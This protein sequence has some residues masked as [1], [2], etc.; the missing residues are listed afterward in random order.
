MTVTINQLV[1]EFSVSNFEKS[2]AFYVKILGFSIAYQREEEGFAFL[3]LGEAQIMID[4][5]GKGRTWVTGELNYPLG[6]GI[7]FQIK[8]KSIDPVLDKLKQN[9]VELFLGVEEK[10]YRQDTC[11][12]GNKQFLVMDPDGYLLRF[13]EDLGTKPLYKY[14]ET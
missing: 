10:W 12:V 4:E 14:K 2:L 5:I 6:R 1:P 11:E 13:T 9:G 3:T 8:V 7:N